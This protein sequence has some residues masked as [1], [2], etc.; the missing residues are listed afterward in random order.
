ML[1]NQRVGRGSLELEAAAP[2]HR[3]SPHV[4]IFFPFWN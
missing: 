2:Q 4:G 1:M 3:A